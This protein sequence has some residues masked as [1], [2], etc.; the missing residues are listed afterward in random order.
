MSDK[1]NSPITPPE[2]HPKVDA[3]RAVAKGVFG[4]IPVVGSAIAEVIE[5]I[6]PDPTTADRIRWELQVS[7]QLNR[8]T[9]AS[10][11][12]QISH[13]TFAWKLALFANNQDTNANGEVAIGD[14]EIA[15]HFPD[16]SIGDLEDALSDLSKADWIS[17]WPDANSRNGIGGFFT[18]PLLFAHTDP[19]V[20]HTS[21]II[22][23]K[24]VASF[25]LDQDGKE[26]ISAMMIEETV[27]L[28]SRRLYPALAFL[29]EEV[30]PSGT[31]EAQYHP[32]YPFIW[33]HLNGS[34]RQALR[35]FVED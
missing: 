10:G 8:L 31:F 13:D 16:L 22:D 33:L 25:I 18:K 14:T 19:F 34:S 32:K 20:R 3:A 6:A 30:L 2:S 23:A 7:T 5:Y 9:A 1:T 24:S 12:R 11:R 15:A 21:P 28:D 26:E 29:M 35:Q 27:E 4:A 17:C